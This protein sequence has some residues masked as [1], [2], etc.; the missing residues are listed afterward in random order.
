MHCLVGPL[1]TVPRVLH[2]PINEL[3][4]VAVLCEC[5]PERAHPRHTAIN[6]HLLPYDEATFI[7]REKHYHL[8]LFDRF[9]ES[10]RREMYLAPITFRLVSAQE[11]LE[12]YRLVNILP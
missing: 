2:R 5:R 8:C 10:S 9:S 7:A 3:A 4:I 12:Y 6:N 1:E 11:L